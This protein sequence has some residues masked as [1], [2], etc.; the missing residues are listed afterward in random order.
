VDEEPFKEFGMDKVTGVKLEKGYHLYFVH[1]TG[2]G[3]NAISWEPAA[4][5]SKRA[6]YLVSHVKM[7]GSLLQP[8][9]YAECCIHHHKKFGK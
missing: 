8:L 4:H 2:Y 3:N 9:L 6:F 7:K 5:I 1:C